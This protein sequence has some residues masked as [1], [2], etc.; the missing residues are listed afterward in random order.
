[1][2]INLKP[3]NHPSV[4]YGRDMK[5]NNEWVMTLDDQDIAELDKA[6]KNVKLHNLSV[7]HIGKADFPIP[8]LA[9]KLRKVSQ[10][11]AGRGFVLIRGLPIEKYGIPDAALVYWGIGSHLGPAFAQNAQGDMLCNIKDV[12]VDWTID[13]RA[14]GYQTNE[15][16]P[17]HN[18]STD[19]VGLL[20]LKTAK[21][22]GESR[23]VSSTAVHNE[24]IAR[25]PDL[26]EI[27]CQPFYVDRRGEESGGQR[28]YYVQ[29]C[30]N[31]HAGRPFIRYNRTF[32]ESAQRFEEV[33]RL[34]S[35][36]IQALDLMD[37]LCNDST[38]H[39]SMDFQPGDIQFVCNYVVMHSRS[40][41]EDWPEIERRRHLLRLWL[42]IPGF[43]DLPEAFRDRNEDMKA[44]QANPR[45]P[46]FNMA[47]TSGRLSH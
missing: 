16:L 44:W 30:F 7:P 17:F 18:D 2:K 22:G 29:P 40:N 32:I 33:P 28:P 42:N 46:I 8:R 20:C 34:T 31:Y 13:M 21:T 26:F 36:H 9:T 24:F 3:I 45:P 39:L 37:E 43:E 47:E 27:M 11:L 41:Y 15:R 19:V 1:M 23:L 14:R 10:E 35:K 4:W 5:L 6:L 38:I 25:R 12:G